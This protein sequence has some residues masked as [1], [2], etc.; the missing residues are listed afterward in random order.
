[1]Q[2]DNTNLKKYLLGTLSESEN[3][4]LDL[5]IISDESFAEELSLAEH[6]LI[7]DNLEGS[8]S[9]DEAAVFESNFLVS[10]ERHALLRE[11]SLLK[12]FAKKKTGSR[13]QEEIVSNPSPR[14]GFFSFYFRPILAVAAILVAVLA[15]GLI[16]NIYL[17]ETRT[18][19]ESEYAELNKRDLGDLA[20]LANYYPINLSSGTFR[21]TALASKQSADKLTGTVLFRLALPVSTADNAVFQAKIR[22]TGAPDFTLSDVHAYRNPNGQEIRLLVPKEILQKGQYQITVQSKSDG[23]AVSAYVFEVE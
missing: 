4:E 2:G 19:L 11:I 13:E 14:S 17:R 23:A 3:E 15:L 22:R 1:M 18:P 9:S 6:E 21:N 5:R 20:Q 12:E 16:W 7:E 8:L 10:L